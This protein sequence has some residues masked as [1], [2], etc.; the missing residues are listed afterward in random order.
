MGLK[1]PG[2]LPL[3]I[4]EQ[5][6][7]V[8]GDVV[9]GLIPATFRTIT[10]VGMVYCRVS[11]FILIFLIKMLM[12]M[13]EVDIGLRPATL[14]P[15]TQLGVVDFRLAMLLHFLLKNNCDDERGDINVG[16]GRRGF[17]SKEIIHSSFHNS[18]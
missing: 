12:V 13:R 3:T 11:Y 17:R 16:G 5:V 10:Q 1:R 15:I 6:L 8:M 9:I 18:G 2:I 4:V 14:L 7:I